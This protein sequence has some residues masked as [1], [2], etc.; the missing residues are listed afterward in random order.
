MAIETVFSRQVSCFSD[1]L[2]LGRRVLVTASTQGLGWHIGV[3]M[4]Q[5]GAQVCLNGRHPERLSAAVQKARQQCEG[6]LGTVQGLCADMATVAGI[7]CALDFYVQGHCQILVNNIG[8]RHRQP[9]SQTSDTAMQAMVQSNIVAPMMLSQRMAND[10]QSG[11]SIINMASVAGPIARK[12]DAVYPV[13]KHAMAA[14]T[15]SLAVELA[16]KGVRVN[17]I[18]PGAFD[19]ESN[20]QLSPQARAH[21]LSRIPMG[22]FGQP[23]E[24]A[25]LAVFLA[26]PASTY[27]TGQVLRLDGGLSV[28]F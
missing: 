3:A 2:L 16:D 21:M 10:M 7:E 11:D 25:T 24:V 15:H 23:E 18:A 6:T 12:G 4:A 20:A 26:S 13:T 19:T 22:R 28:L 17:A 9:W 5:L 8:M 1:Q 14:M 27:L